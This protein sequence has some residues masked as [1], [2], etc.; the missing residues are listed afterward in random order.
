MAAPNG[1]VNSQAGPFLFFTAAGS[2]V[3]RDLLLS[4]R[5]RCFWVTDLPEVDR[6]AIRV[7]V[8]ER[9]LQEG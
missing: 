3:Y 8:D 7:G 4:R 5:R 6:E 1:P 2:P 9:R